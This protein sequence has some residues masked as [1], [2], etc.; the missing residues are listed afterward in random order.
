MVESAHAE[1]AQMQRSHVHS[2]DVT[3]H[4]CR[5]SC[6]VVNKT[7]PSNEKW[8]G[9]NFCFIK[10]SIIKSDLYALI[11][12]GNSEFKMCSAK[13]LLSTST[14]VY[15]TDAVLYIQYAQF[16]VG[17]QWQMPAHDI[18]HMSTGYYSNSLLQNVSI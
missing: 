2:T 13:I 15:K 1:H 12:T 9:L 18:T 4:A 7:T 10:Y 6:E 14:A 17:D 5:N 16:D 3:A 11:R 8:N